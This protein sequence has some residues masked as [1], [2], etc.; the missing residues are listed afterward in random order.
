MV[1]TITCNKCGNEQE[2]TS[3]SKRVTDKMSIDVYVQGT[4]QGDAVRSIDISCESINCTNVISL[5]Y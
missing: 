1:F 3:G 2:Y 5:K 4:Y